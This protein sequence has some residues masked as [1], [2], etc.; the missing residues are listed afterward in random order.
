MPNK[1]FTAPVF[2]VVNR[3]AVRPSGLA[4]LVRLNVS[5]GQTDMVSIWPKAVDEPQKL[6]V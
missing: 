6:R 4:S 3:F 2:Q 5:I 1:V